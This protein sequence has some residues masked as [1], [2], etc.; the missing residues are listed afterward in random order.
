MKTKSNINIIASICL[1]AAVGGV[2][3]ASLFD[4][5]DPIDIPKYVDPLP[6]PKKLTGGKLTIT[7]SEFEQQVLPTTD[8]NN[9]PTGFKKTVVWGYD[10]TYPGP[11]IDIK[12]QDTTTI[13]W[14]NKLSNATL[15][16]DVLV[17][18]KTLNWANPL[19]KVS[20]DLP[21]NGPVPIVTHLHGGM[22]SSNV[23]GNP[24]K[25]FLPNDSQKYL[26]LND[27]EAATLWYHDHTMGVTRLN[28]Y[29][30]LAGFYLLRDDFE[31]ELQLPGNVEKDDKKY[32][33]EIVIQD[34]LFDKFGQLVFPSE[35]VNKNDH[36]S[37]VP[38]FYGDIL[39]VNGKTWPYLD[40]EPRRYRLRL[41]NG[42]NA[43]FYTLSFKN[44]LTFWQISTDAGLLDKPVN[45]S[46][47]TLAP[48]ERADVIVD[49]SSKKGTDLILSNDSL[50][51]IPND[52]VNADGTV[53]LDDP[54]R[55]VM[56]FRVGKSVTKADNTFNPARVP[57]PSLRAKNPIV[58]LAKV[59]PVITRTMTLNEV[60]G[61]DGP[62]EV[63]VDGKRFDA[64][65][66]ETPKEGTTEIWQIVNLTVD[67]HPMHLH[68][69][70]FQLLNRQKID[71]KLYQ[72]RYDSANPKLP[73][74]VTFNP[75]LTADIFTDESGFTYPVIQPDEN[76]NGWK[77]TLRMNPG[78]VTRIAVRFAP[79][80]T[81]A[82][83]LNA[84]FPFDP[85]KGP[86]YVW[87]CH[88]IDHEDNE[89]MRPYKVIR[90]K[91]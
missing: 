37:W 31:K 68:L 58:R 22:V 72:D 6:M 21:Y 17:V 55:Q 27:Q 66:T 8:S 54:T 19:P 77:D 23:D 79:T 82:N 16:R 41:L 48:G 78:E 7:A 34:R 90:A 71:K 50:I 47:L 1:L 29:A 56:Q 39:V 3:A 33:R 15:Y 32:E 91:K 64:K 26:Y 4:P 57:T 87:H 76:E 2:Q 81:P 70:P 85:S 59:A 20:L 25:W 51:P 12:R 18:D 5:L 38:E 62:L 89:M 73:A 86:G 30:G 88:I 74:P 44:G 24:D 46:N 11:T 49:F 14:V 67:K 84:Q 9:V 53:T 45:V 10:G 52:T 60:Q 83:M 75:E 35:G 36:P 69:V 40:V 42:S 28:V 80:E 13:N 63:L 61:K 65:V 43:R